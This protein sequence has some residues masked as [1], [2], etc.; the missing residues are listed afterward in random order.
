MLAKIQTYLSS[1]IKQEIHK[2]LLGAQGLMLG[3]ACAVSAFL[4]L[5]INQYTSP[6]IQF[7]ETQKS[8]ALMAEVV[9][10]G[11][12]S[13]DVLQQATTYEVEGI[14]YQFV[15]VNGATG[16]P[17]YQVITAK[18]AG[19][20]G[21]IQF[22]V[23]VSLS[24]EITNVRVLSHTETPGLGDKIE[25]DKSDWVLGFNRRSLENTAIWQ[26][27]KDGG[28]FEQFSGATIT[29]RAVVKG[30]HLALQAQREINQGGKDE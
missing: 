30:V 17:E 23:G 1:E 14:S 7:N 4:L 25:L 8:L 11:K 9:P 6:I 12:I 26:V 22:I 3:S 27:Q 29:P 28:D 21:D 15:T 19:Y 10:M 20:S 24:G 18:T 2:D 13:P 5:A 16:K